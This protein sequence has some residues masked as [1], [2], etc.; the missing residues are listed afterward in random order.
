MLIYFD[1]LLLVLERIFVMLYVEF[2]Q[3]SDLFQELNYLFVSH[4]TPPC[5]PG[6]LFQIS[7]YEAGAEIR[8]AQLYITLRSPFTTRPMV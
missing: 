7:T 1:G 4:D 6:T 8:N 2:L 3:V 5:F